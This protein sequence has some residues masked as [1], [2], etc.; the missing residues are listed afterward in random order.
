MTEDKWSRWLKDERWGGRQQA[1]Q[2]ALNSVRDRIMGMAAPQ[3][4]ETV[5]DLGSGTGLLGLEAARLVGP[6]GRVVCLDVSEP[7]LRT[8]AAQVTIGC[9]RFAVAE[10][11]ALPLRA[12]C[13]DAVVMRSVLIYVPDRQAAAAEMARV[14][15]S[16]GRVAFF[17][18][19]NRRMPL[20]VDLPDF[21]DVTQAYLLGR[22][23]NPLCNFEEHD[24]VA[25]FEGA[26]FT[27][28]LSMDESRWPT[29][30]AEWSHVF[31]Y[32]APAGYNAYDTALAGG[33]TEERLDE[34]LVAGERQLG[35]AWI[36]M[37]CPAAYLLAI[38][39]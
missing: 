9:E 19:I 18:P 27:V 32:G 10:A 5:V 7:A 13:A 26:G 22:E 3:A 12:A 30:G 36:V 24:L 15:R 20:G 6:E 8:A 37:T 2:A 33:A 31:R 11:L 28:Q 4:G 25:A 16:G 29:R 23:S 35:D 1:L 14:L 39:T 34:F 38:R 21:V 17:E